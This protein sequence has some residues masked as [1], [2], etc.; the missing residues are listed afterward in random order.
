[1]AHG[2]LHVGETAIAEVASNSRIGVW[3]QCNSSGNTAAYL[4]NGVVLPD[5]SNCLLHDCRSENVMLG[6][7]CATAV[8]G[9][10]L[11]D[12]RNDAYLG[13]P[14]P[15]CGTAGRTAHRA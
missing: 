14:Q 7:P 8:L 10:Q 9:Q 1:M 13:G 12:Q 11:P 15:W 5:L 6:E 4:L 2:S 3:R